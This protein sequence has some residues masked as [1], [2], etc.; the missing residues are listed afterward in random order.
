V[1]KRSRCS[2]RGAGNFLQEGLFWEIKRKGKVGA[3]KGILTKQG[4]EPAG[5]ETIE[6]S[7][8]WHSL[9]GRKKGRWEMLKGKKNALHEKSTKKSGL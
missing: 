4:K 2:T 7:A 9:A 1:K 6:L 3:P 8:T 5:D